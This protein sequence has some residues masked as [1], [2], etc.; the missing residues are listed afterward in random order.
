[1]DNGM[2]KKITQV[3][4]AQEEL[5][6]SALSKNNKPTVQSSSFTISLRCL[7]PWKRMFDSFF[8]FFPLWIET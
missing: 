7:G 8:H 6:F 2:A 4:N 5:P 3:L 1:M